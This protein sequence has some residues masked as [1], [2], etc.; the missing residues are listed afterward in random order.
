M[1]N[2]KKILIVDDSPNDIRFLMENLKDRY[3][4]LVAT[5]GKKALDIANKEDKPDVIL[6]DVSMPELDGYETCT[7]MKQSPETEHI[8]IIFVTA[9]DTIEEKLKGYQVGGSDYL[10]K[11]IEPVV[12]MQKVDIILKNREDRARI[13]KAADSARSVAMT[14]MMD[15][16]EQS[17]IM[18]FMRNSYAVKSFDELAALIVASCSQYELDSSVQIRTPWQIHD[19]GKVQP[20]PPLESELMFKLQNSGR[21]HTLGKRLLINCDAITILVKNLPNDDSKVGRLRDHLAHI[22]EGANAR[23]KMLLIEHELNLLVKDSMAT[24]SNIQASLDDQKQSFVKIMD[25]VKHD[26]QSSFLSYGLTEDQENI[27]INIVE[28]AEEESIINFEQGLKIDEQFL[29]I[30]DR[31][32]TFSNK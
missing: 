27:L 17:V 8:D 31:L 1:D 24:L 25:K 29:E 3:A 21:I 11:P 19:H 20:I 18:G 12:L 7:L 4:I 32:K 2:R 6:L 26:V 13:S 10:V 14:A 30:I 15:S 23:F 16:G 5:D 9:N 28:T 22:I